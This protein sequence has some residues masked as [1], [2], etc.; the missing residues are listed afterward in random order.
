MHK[1]TKEN[2]SEVHK[3]LVKI[4]T[5]NETMAKSNKLTTAFEMC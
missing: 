2:T 3:V 4:V 5:T 1:Q